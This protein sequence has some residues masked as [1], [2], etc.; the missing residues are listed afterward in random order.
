[1]MR[2][3]AVSSKISGLG[4]RNDMPGVNNPSSEHAVSKAVANMIAENIRFILKYDC[5]RLCL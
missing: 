5:V 1:M 3:M 2:K 4:V